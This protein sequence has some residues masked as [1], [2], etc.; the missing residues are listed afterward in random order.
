MLL[1]LLG[2]MLGAACGADA[3]GPPPGGDTTLVIVPRT[4]LLTP[5]DSIRLR[6]VVSTATGDT[7]DS[8]VGFVARDPAV[9]SV[10][11]QGLVRGEGLGTTWIVADALG[12]LDSVF[13]TVA[14][15]VALPGLRLLTDQLSEPVFLTQPPGESDRLFVVEQGGRIRILRNDVLLARP[16]LDLTAVVS[17]PPLGER[18]LLSMAFDPGY[19]QNGFFYASYT[20]RQG[21]S[22]PTAEQE[23]ALAGAQQ[24]VDGAGLVLRG[25]KRVQRPTA[26]S[27]PIGRGRCRRRRVAHGQHAALPGLTGPGAGQGQEHRARRPVDDPMGEAQR[28]AGGS[29]EQRF[30]REVGQRAVGQ[31]Q[32][33]LDRRAGDRSHQ[34]AVGFVGRAAPGRVPGGL[35]DQVA[36]DAHQRGQGVGRP[37]AQ[38][39]HGVGADPPAEDRVVAPEEGQQRA[40]GAHQSGL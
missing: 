20:D 1:I 29:R 33:V 11:A 19:Q 30:E 28:R 21:D 39:A 14:A 6:G 4:V 38:G 5:G 18:G 24:V 32:Q 16:F 7:L 23:I 25:G 36:Q 26:Q 13:A 9:A 12:R 3:V 31:D 35:G 22:G 34:P 8:P 17:P 40:V 27:V 2:A 15:N 37:Q 10:T